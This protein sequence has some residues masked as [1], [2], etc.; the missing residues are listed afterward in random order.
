MVKLAERIELY[1]N[2]P[3]PPS[4]ALLSAVPIPHPKE[5]LCTL[6][7][8]PWVVLAPAAGLGPL[9]VALSMLSDGIEAAQQR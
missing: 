4:Q 2:P 7:H 8:R 6:A 5:R 9:V 3:H 1:E